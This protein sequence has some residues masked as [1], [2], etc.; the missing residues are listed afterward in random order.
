QLLDQ[1]SKTVSQGVY[2]LSNDKK[3]NLSEL[4]DLPE[5]NLGVDA[6]M[7]PGAINELS[8]QVKLEN[9]GAEQGGKTGPIALMVR[10]H[11]TKGQAGTPLGPV[12]LDDNYFSLL[13]GEKRMIPG[14]IPLEALNGQEAHLTV[15]GW[16]VKSTPGF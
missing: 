16:N 7:S 4:T 2:C 9:L 14:R 8:F 15:D 13:P 12:F 6:M 3:Y 5:A 1:D 11:L 10:L